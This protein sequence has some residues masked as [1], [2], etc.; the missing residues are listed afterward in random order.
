MDTRKHG[1]DPSIFQIKVTL[2]GIKPPI[3][4]RL[5]VRNDTTLADLHDILQVAFGWTDSHLHQFRVDDTYYGK[6]DPDYLDHF[7]MHDEQE[8]TLDQIAAGEGFTFRY[9]YDFGDS[10]LHRLVVE[11]V[12]PPEPGRDYPVCIKGRRAGP[13]E[14]VGGIWGYANFLE[15][16]ADPTHEEHDSYLEWIGDEFDPEALDLEEINQALD[17]LRRGMG[18]RPADVEFALGEE[19][20]LELIERGAAV[21]KP[22][23]PMVDWVNQTVSFSTPATLAELKEDCTVLLVPDLDSHQEVLDYLEPFKLSLFEME[24]EDWSGDP[25]TWP[26]ERTAEVFDAWFDIQ[27]HSM[28]WDV[29]EEAGEEGEEEDAALVVSGTWNVL[30]SPDLDD[31]YLS[32]ET[33]PYLR[34]EQSGLE[35][36]GEFQVGLIRG[37]IS[38]RS[39]G[40]LVLF[41]FEGTDELDPVHGAGIIVLHEETMLLRLMFHEGDAFTF[42]C[43]RAED[44]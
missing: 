28:V 22:K 31:D 38:G 29:V 39:E 24:L 1:S 18:R 42:V 23:Q 7:P 20:N 35:I 9:E 27:V 4:R 5:L 30:S 10:W 13:P 17:A 43:S 19:V 3:W 26:E 37:S 8:V 25:S 2:E 6:P 34:L 21:I 15:A 11:K 12:L 41:S 16:M 36:S 32:M 40:R 33:T 44:A 14:D